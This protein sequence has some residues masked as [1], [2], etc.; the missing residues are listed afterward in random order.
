MIIC[1]YCDSENIGGADLCE[2]CGQ[3]LDDLHLPE[4]AT[5]VERALLRDRVA[6]LRPKR[7]VVVAPSTPLREVL[8]TM[9]QRGIGCV[10]VVED[11]KLAGIFS[12]RD[13][14]M[15]VHTRAAELGGRPVSEFMTAKVETLLP[16]AKIAFAVHRMDLGGYRHV[17]IVDESGAPTGVISVRDILGYLTERMASQ[18]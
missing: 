11:G 12:E 18:A 15:K 16:T 3:P 5:A 13:V 7:P 6:V 8:Q 2:Q 17:P 9:L 1:P 10:L 14:L 4:P